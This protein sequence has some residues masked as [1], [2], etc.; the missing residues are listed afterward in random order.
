MEIPIPGKTFFILR[1]SPGSYI[2]S[3]AVI[4]PINP[5]YLDFTHSIEMTAT[6]HESELKV[7]TNIPYFTLR[8]SYGV[9]VVRKLE[10]TDWVSA[11]LYIDQSSPELRWVRQAPPDYPNHH[12]NH[13]RRCLLPPLLACSS[14]QMA[15]WQYPATDKTQGP[16]WWINGE[17]KMYSPAPPNMIFV[18]W[19]Y[20]NHLWCNLNT[21]GPLTKIWIFLP[22]R[23]VRLP[24]Q[25][26]LWAEMLVLG[27]F[28]GAKSEK[29]KKVLENFF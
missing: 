21:L 12:P 27:H 24:W 13:L 29:L 2:Q 1:Q 4:T 16:F 6:D 28:L 15:L 3:S 14:W 23:P 25:P 20:V 22:F 17:K 9:S 5:I 8:A 19:W 11:A 18:F 7:T 26:G 10:E